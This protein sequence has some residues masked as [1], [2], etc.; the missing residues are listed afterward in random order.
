[1]EDGRSFCCH[2]GKYSVPHQAGNSRKEA[3]C[4]SP[5][6]GFQEEGEKVGG[7]S[8]SEVRFEQVGL[9]ESVNV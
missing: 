5:R 7:E 6:Q 4:P 9:A 8:D 1:M 2:L 3:W